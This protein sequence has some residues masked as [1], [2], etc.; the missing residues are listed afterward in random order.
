MQIALLRVD[1]ARSQLQAARLA[2]L[3]SLSLSPQ[4]ALSRTDGSKAVKTYELP[5]QASWEID[6]FGKLRNAKQETQAALL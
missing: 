6:L 5:I 2:F 3:P 4:G 1:Q